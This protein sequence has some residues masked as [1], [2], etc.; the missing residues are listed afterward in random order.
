MINNPPKD[1]QVAPLAKAKFSHDR[2]A[3]GTTKIPGVDLPPLAHP[4]GPDSSYNL[5]QLEVQIECHRDQMKDMAKMY[6]MRSAKRKLRKD[7][8]EVEA[9]EQLSK[10][11]D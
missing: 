8:L 10:K 1:T 11:A 9:A 5:E 2:V 3:S 6:E 4:Q 7:M